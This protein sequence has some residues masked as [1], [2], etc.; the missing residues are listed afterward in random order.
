MQFLHGVLAVQFPAMPS[1]C[2][3]KILQQHMKS[4]RKI[5]VIE[6]EVNSEEAK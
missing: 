1:S 2:T 3:L 5:K 6:I 4:D